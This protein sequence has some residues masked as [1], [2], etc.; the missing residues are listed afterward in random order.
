MQDEPW[1]VAA[2]ALKLG[3]TRKV[4]HGCGDLKAAHINHSEDGWSLYCHRCGDNLFIPKPLP[5]LAERSQRAQERRQAEASTSASLAPPSPQ[6]WALEA[7]PAAA[8]V[9]LYKAGLSNADIRKLG[10]YYHKPTHRVV[11]PTITDGSLSFWQARKLEGDGPKYLSPEGADRS[12]VIAH[13]GT[14]SSIVI[15]EDALSAY[16]VGQ[17]AEGWSLLGTKLLKPAL[18]KLIRLN[19]PVVIWLDNDTGGSRNSGQLAALEIKRTL[20]NVGITTRNIITPKDPK[21][22]SRREIISVLQHT[23]LFDELRH[24]PVTSDEVPQVFHSPIRHGESTRA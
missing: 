15:V 18:S 24:H 20:E 9:W 12:K 17:V 3:G 7:W 6:E 21:A 16:R 19:K 23:G 4:R 11:I 2:K 5:S 22:Y 13:F 14:A 8:L 10:A 1:L